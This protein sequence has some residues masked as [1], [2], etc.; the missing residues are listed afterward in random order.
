MSHRVLMT[1]DAVG[2]VWRYAIDL[3]AALAESGHRVT[4]AGLGPRPDAAQRQEAE[5][6]GPL[7]W[8][9]AP[10]D[11][12]ASGPQD[13]TAVA[14]WIEGLA[15]RHRAE[16]LHLN[17]PSQAAGLTGGP[18]VVAVCHS[19][20]ATWFRA[21]E[22]APVPAHLAWVAEA[23]RAG[24]R[25]ADAVVAPSEAH[26]ALTAGVYGLTGI[27]AVPNAGRS[28]FAIADGSGAGVVAVARW[29]DRAKNGAVLDAAAALTSV[30]VTMIG[31]TEGAD[32]QRFVASSA[33]AA[34]P[35]PHAETVRRVASAA[36]FVSPSL[37]EPFGLAAL[38]AARAG[39]PLILADIPVYR[40]LWSDAARFFAPHDP[41]ALAAA[42]DALAADPEERHRLGAAAQARAG[43]FSP[44]AQAAAMAAIYGDV[45]AIRK[46]S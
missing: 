4:F 35:L 20:L 10:L 16:V 30:P 26:A 25:R 3:G 21:M 29:W 42:I 7:A 12:M 28:P 6:I 8:G 1:L 32:G 31:A 41:R 45:T 23:T 36:I 46:A 17:L 44:A 9:D 19:C 33:A 27:A 38:E 40:E 15:R 22:E 2:G 13:L 34:G 18:P 14:P 24:L 37:Y 11:W 43:R 39:R 5:A